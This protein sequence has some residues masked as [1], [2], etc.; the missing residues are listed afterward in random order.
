VVELH[1]DVELLVSNAGE[2]CATLAAL[3]ISRSS[4][5]YSAS[6]AAAMML[7][8]GVRAEFTAAG[9]VVTSSFLG[10]I[11]TD[12]TAGIEIPKAS[13]RSVAARSLD[14]LQAEGASV[15]P[16]RLA[17]LVEDAVLTNMAAVLEDPQAV[18]GRLI[19][20]LRRDE[21]TER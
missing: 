1:G 8:M 10:F 20:A 5:I 12:M 2:T 16:D 13:P 4:P 6:K 9:V 3:V 15:F 19:V 11:D 18:M 17:E 21:G 14:T 7:A